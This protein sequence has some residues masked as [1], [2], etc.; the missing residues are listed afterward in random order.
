VRPCVR[1]PRRE[2]GGAANR[3]VGADVLLL[4]GEGQALQ[5]GPLGAATPLLPLA[6]GSGQ[7]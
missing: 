5:G 6:G 2:G 1:V 3:L 7:A 4:L